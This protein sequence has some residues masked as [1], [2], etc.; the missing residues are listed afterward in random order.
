M[1]LSMDATVLVRSQ[2][3]GI[4][5]RCAVVDV[6]VCEATKFVNKAQKFSV[7]AKMSDSLEDSDGAPE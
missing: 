7:P 1:A 4:R 2:R 5:D 3:L 6:Y